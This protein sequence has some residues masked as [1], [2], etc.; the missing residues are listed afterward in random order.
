[1]P[2][3]IRDLILTHQLHYGDPPNAQCCEA[4][5]ATNSVPHRVIEY[6]VKTYALIK[7]DVQAS[8]SIGPGKTVPRISIE[9]R[10]KWRRDSDFERE[11]ARS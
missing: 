8:G 6:W 1:M 5:S 7:Q 11:I 2:L 4:G 10:I 9:D 3:M